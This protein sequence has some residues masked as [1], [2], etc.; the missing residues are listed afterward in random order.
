MSKEFNFVEIN[1]SFY[2]QPSFETLNR[3]KETVPEDFKFCVK[4]NRYFT[5]M[6]R[7]SVDDAFKN[8]WFLFWETI[9]SLQ[10]KLG[11]VLFQLPPI[12]L[13][14]LNR[15]LILCRLEALG[16]ILAKNQKF[17]FECRDKSWD[18][19]VIAELFKKYNWCF[20]IIHVNNKTHW[21][22]D[23]DDGFFPKNEE[24]WV[25]AKWGSYARFHGSEGQYYGSYKQSVL[26]EF[27]C[28]IKKQ[29][30]KLKVNFVAFNNTDEHNKLSSAIKDA[31]L[32]KQLIKS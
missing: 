21:A 2:R 15:E 29:Q 1:N 25:T 14:D 11:P 5:H 32:L 13:T 24:L 6:K 30:E 18:N 7:L 19:R 23:L 8:K 17:V 27:I 28:K 10:P 9:L 3:W 22:G 16:N 31:R 20:C 12:K 4:V 26:D